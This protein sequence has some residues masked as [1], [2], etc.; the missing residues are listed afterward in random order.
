MLVLLFLF[1]LSFSRLFP[2]LK[3]QEEKHKGN[4]IYRSDARREKRREGR[5]EAGEALSACGGGLMGQMSTALAFQIV[6]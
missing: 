3:K 4:D 1:F 6:G 5:R 2:I